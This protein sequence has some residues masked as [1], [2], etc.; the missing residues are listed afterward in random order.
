MKN[1]CQCYLRFCSSGGENCSHIFL[2][3]A[4]AQLPVAHSPLEWMCIYKRGLQTQQ[5]CWVGSEAIETFY[6][7]YPDTKVL[8]CT[9][10]TT[11]CT[12]SASTDP[13]CPKARTQYSFVLSVSDQTLTPSSAQLCSMWQHYKEYSVRL[14][15]LLSCNCKGSSI[16][17][18]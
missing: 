2:Q 4:R 1:S 6:I 17:G 3:G 9:S 11:L 8:L 7:Q 14:A 5:S 12:W 10:P 16:S 18:L 15:L 13:G